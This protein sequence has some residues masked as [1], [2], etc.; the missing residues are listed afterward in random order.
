MAER[1]A[2]AGF[3]SAV[4]APEESLDVAQAA[5][6]IARSEY[7]DL[8]VDAYLD[9]LRELGAAFER[10]AMD[11][12][13]ERAVGLLR[14]Y[15]FDQEGFRGN[16]ADYYDP[17]N[18]FLNQVLDRRVGIPIS[19]SAVYIAVAQR[20]GLRAAGVSFPGHFIVRVEGARGPLW[21]DPFHGGIRLSA[22]DLQLRLDRMY[23][24]RVALKNEMLEPCT[25]RTM[26]ARL[27]RN[28]KAIY[29]RASDQARA[30]KIVE[31]LV[32]LEPLNREERR[33][34]GLLLASMECYGMAADAL[35][36]YL[37]ETPDAPDARE[38]AGRI[39]GLRERA[40]RLN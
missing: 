25:K 4:S 39:R 9:R 5:L 8:D 33:D 2:R 35:D 14:E 15:L 3:A 38:I 28:L 21:V 31:Q 26:L 19:L 18:S 13:P 29:V 27:L 12:T 30:L 6:W 40:A 10:R 11:A 36:V 37:Q 17:R 1:D 20:A 7:A 24:S 22:T 34:R 32:L 23:A 16:D